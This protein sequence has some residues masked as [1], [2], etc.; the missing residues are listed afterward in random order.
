MAERTRVQ[1]LGN[2]WYYHKWLVLLAAA[3]LGIG[4]A[5]FVPWSDPTQPD[6]RVGYVAAQ[7]LDQ[8]TAARLQAALEGIGE[9]INGDGQVVIALEQYVVVFRGTAA[10]ANAQMAGIARLS[11]DLCAADGPAI[12]LLDDPAGLQQSIGALQY[13]DGTQPP[14]EPPYDAQNWRRMVYDLHDCPLLAEIL[15]APELYI[16]RRAESLT[17]APAGCETLWQALTASVPEAS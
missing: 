16:A 15:D 3:L 10:D 14:E 17:P 9:D 7:P 12:F 8:D 11:A 1:R 6:L 13:L 2:W 5:L 4:I